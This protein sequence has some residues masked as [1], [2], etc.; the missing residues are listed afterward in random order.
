MTE[1]NDHVLEFEPI[2][3]STFNEKTGDNR[4]TES[5]AGATERYEKAEPIVPVMAVVPVFLFMK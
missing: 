2:T 5:L 4:L 1:E 3:K